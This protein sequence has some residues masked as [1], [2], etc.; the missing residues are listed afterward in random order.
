MTD[1]VRHR[2]ENEWFA[3]HEE[4]LLRQARRRHEQRLKELAAQQVAGEKRTLRDL[5]HMKCPKCGHDMA[6]KHIDGV[7][8]DRCGTCD[9][10]F[11][12]KGEFEEILLK[13]SE[14]RRGFF[15]KLVGL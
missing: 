2:V 7:E 10:L 3:R 5:H 12:D 6:A 15:R 4:E 9:G 14:D 13:R 8:V 1:E 11:F